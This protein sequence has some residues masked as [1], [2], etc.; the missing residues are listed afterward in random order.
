MRVLVGTISWATSDLQ[1]PMA[2]ICFLAAQSVLEYGL[3]EDVVYRIGNQ[4]I[5]FRTDISIKDLYLGSSFGDDIREHFFTAISLTISCLSCLTSSS[6]AAS[7]DVHLG[8]SACMIPTD[9]WWQHA[10]FMK[11]RMDTRKH[12]DKCPMYHTFRS[13]VIPPCQIEL[14]WGHFQFTLLF[15]RCLKLGNVTAEY[16]RRCYSMFTSCG[17][18]LCWFCQVCNP[19]NLVS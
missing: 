16:L 14:F 15:L 17:Q 8:M 2:A 1:Q 12:W 18:E 13:V 9:R 4:P 3:W 11:W 10:L 5:A 6:L 19:K 7:Q